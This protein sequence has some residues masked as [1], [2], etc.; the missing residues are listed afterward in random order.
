MSVIDEVKYS[1]DDPDEYG[2]NVNVK[3]TSKESS[4]INDQERAELISKSVKVSEELFPPVFFSIDNAIKRLKINNENINFYIAPDAVA[5]AQCR[6]TPFSVYVDIIIASRLIELLDKDE[7]SFVIGHEL[8]HYL[9][10][11]YLYPHPNLAF[12]ELDNINLL[13]LSKSAEISADR[14]GLISCG[15]V[16]FALKAMLKTASGLPSNYINFN[17]GVY[18]KQLTD[19]KEI[20]NNIS[21]LYSTHPSFLN[22]IQSLI[23]FSKTDLYTSNF[24][25]NENGVYKKYEIDE[26]INQSI[27]EVIG[28]EG[29]RKNTEVYQN[30]KLWSSLDLF[31]SDD[32]FSKKEQE[33]FKKEFDEENLNNAR[34]F[35]KLG[36]KELEKK[37]DEHTTQAIALTKS[38]KEKLMKELSIIAGKI[39]SEERVL[40]QKLSKLSSRLGL[41]KAIT[42]IKDS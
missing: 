6:V 34:S 26:K 16:K 20:K 23:W 30:L 2:V 17:F 36:S 21:Q 29:H 27:I 14:L 39:E 32:T 22:R 7:L 25:S 18:L 4:R 9:Y 24:T 3:K 10:K 40:L 41:N 13:H 37:I 42:I 38:D 28:K 15:N 31:L 8:A 12:S 19:L 5:N 35:L 1:K 33:M 11:H